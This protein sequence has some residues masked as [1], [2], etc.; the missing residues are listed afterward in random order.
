MSKQNHLLAG[1][2]KPQQKE[3]FNNMNYMDMQELKAFCIASGIPFNIYIEM[4]TGVLKKTS[5]LDR[6]GIVLD[7]IKYYLKTG[8]VKKPTIFTNAVIAKEKLPAILRAN[9]KVLHGQYKN[10]NSAIL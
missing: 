8:L 3:L 7:R 4:P 1:L 10:K 9:H 6:K 5:V 2:T